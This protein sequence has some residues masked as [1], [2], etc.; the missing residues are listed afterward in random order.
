MKSSSSGGRNSSIPW[1][2]SQSFNNK[3]GDTNYLQ[4][5]TNVEKQSSFN[6]VNNKNIIQTS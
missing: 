3:V 1:R 2:D 6:E 4:L 5:I